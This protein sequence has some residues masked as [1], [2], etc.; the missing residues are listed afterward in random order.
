MSVL[1]KAYDER[2]LV[3]YTN[4][5]SRKGRELLAHPEACVNFFWREID[6][7]IRVA[8]PVEQ[9]TD[10]EADAYFQSRARGSRIGAWA[11]QQS[12]P[13][14]SREDLEQAVR[15]IETRFPDDVPVRPTGQGF[16]SNR[17]LTNSGKRANTAC[18]TASSTPTTT[19]VG[20]CSGSFLDANGLA[21]T[22][23][24]RRNG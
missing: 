12:R 22:S 11:S 17:A 24:R 15:E 19:P 6:Q 21:S 23:K 10:G 5:E 20:R 1:L 7:Q 8:G 16:A 9:V 2:G 14:A 4:F 3:F 13:L 18:T